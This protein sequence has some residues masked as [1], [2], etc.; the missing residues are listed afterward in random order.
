MI[1]AIGVYFIATVATAIKYL[2]VD[3]L[4]TNDAV[5][6]GLKWPDALKRVIREFS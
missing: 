2:I 1:L 3:D 4:S 6:K 5:I